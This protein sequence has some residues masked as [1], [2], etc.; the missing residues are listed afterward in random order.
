MNLFILEKLFAL[1]LFNFKSVSNSLFLFNLKL[2]VL[3]SDID[4]F[5]RLSSFFENEEIST[6]IYTCLSFFDL[7]KIFNL[8]YYFEN[9]V[10][11]FP[12][13]VLKKVFII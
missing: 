13:Y 9:G 10:F 7:K 2:S 5:K 8:Y 4:V 11:H 3:S 12:F 1:L 6:F